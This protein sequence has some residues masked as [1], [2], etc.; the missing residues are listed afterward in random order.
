MHQKDFGLRLKL[1][2]LER[3]FTQLELANMLSIS[4]SAYINYETGRT[5]P[6]IETLISLST[7]YDVN[8]LEELNIPTQIRLND[9]KRVMSKLDRHELFSF[10][11]A[12]SELSQK[13]REKV[14]TLIKLLPKG[15]DN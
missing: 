12:Y 4:R 2:R 1:L 8:L 7:I 9:Y 15:G 6:S 14:I 11:D 5:V 13:S 3:K 10:L